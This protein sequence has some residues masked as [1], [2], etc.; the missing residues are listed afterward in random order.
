[1]ELCLKKRKVKIM[2]VNKIYNFEKKTPF[3]N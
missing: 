1:M 3:Q 2:L